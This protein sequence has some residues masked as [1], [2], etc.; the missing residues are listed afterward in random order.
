MDFDLDII[1]KE[2]KKEYSEFI[3]SHAIVITPA[4]EVDTTENGDKVVYKKRMTK[5]SLGGFL[6]NNGFAQSL[7]LAK[8][9]GSDD[10]EKDTYIEYIREK[11][12]FD[13]VSLGQ[14]KFSITLEYAESIME[15]YL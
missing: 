2:V 15:R 11:E 3:D 1:L 7:K 6:V 13:F 5:Q 8:R 12:R 9:W 14:Y 4:K 10:W